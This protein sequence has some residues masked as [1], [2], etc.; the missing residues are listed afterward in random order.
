MKPFSR[1]IFELFDGK[2]RYVVPLYQRQYV[3]NLEEQWKFLWEDIERKILEKMDE[4]DSTPHFLGAM[5]IDQKRTFGNSVPTHLLIDG[6][7]RITTFQILLAVCRDYCEMINQKNYSAEYNRYLLNDGI[8]AEPEIEKFKCW[9]TEVD[10]KQFVD[11]IESQSRKELEIRNPEKWKRY[12]RKPDPRPP[13]IECYLYFF[14]CIKELVESEQ[15][16]GTI[17]ERLNSLLCALRASLQVVTIELEGDDDPQVIFETLNARGQP[18]LPSD[19]L[20]N[21][22]FWRA[23]Q[24]KEQQ[25]TL[26]QKFWI[27]F[28]SNFWKIEEKQ[29]RLLRP[30][31]DIF[32]QHYLAMKQE[33]DI[34]IGHLFIEYKNWIK[35]KQPFK[36]IQEE[37]EDLAFNRENFKLLITPDSSTAIGKFAFAMKSFDITT[38]YPLILGIMAKK[39]DELLFAGMLADIESF[40]V[41]RAVGGYTTKGY[42]KIFISILSNLNKGEFSRDALQKIL[43]DFKSD[44]SLWPN[45]NLFKNAWLSKSVYKYLPSSRIEYLLKKIEVEMRSRK[46][47]EIEIKSDLTI[48]HVLPIDWYDNW[49]LENGSDGVRFENRKDPDIGL[50]NA[51]LSEK[52]DEMLHTL[53]NLTLLTSPLNSS[54]SNQSFKVKKPEILKH[55][56]LLMNRHFV[57]SDSWSETTIMKRGED[58]FEYAKAIWP[59]Y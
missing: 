42:N 10:R 13:M 49:P 3:W 40:I 51:E 27:P 6:Q 22:I 34:N 50:V 2:K 54:I 7:Q 28:D 25:D 38:V 17:E 20:R 5:V 48:E 14:D 47:E 46:S 57:E 33:K 52:R 56:S 15:M 1:S 59:F 44:V 12:A 21:Y 41:R 55:S 43:K 8:M 19:L 37:L 35:T 4:K 32:M 24:T 11:V 29:G 16:H 53:G 9:P 45:D 58:L 31:I 36:T 30:R 26:Y 23:S 39:P 18:L